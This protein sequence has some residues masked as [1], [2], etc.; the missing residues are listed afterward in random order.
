MTTYTLGEKST[1]GGT[2]LFQAGRLASG[3]L[4]K[5]KNWTKVRFFCFQASYPP[6]RIRTVNLELTS[7]NKNI[8][9]R[10]LE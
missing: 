1:F 4:S 8:L 9:K 3:K 5:N 2:E 6:L 10:A 7:V